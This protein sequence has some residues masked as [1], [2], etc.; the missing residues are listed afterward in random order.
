MDPLYH[1]RRRQQ[2]LEEEVQQKDFTKAAILASL[3]AD[4]GIQNER[5][6]SNKT[7][8]KTYGRKA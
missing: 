8:T 6:S 2:H 1:I 5:N 7:K 4:K 3:K